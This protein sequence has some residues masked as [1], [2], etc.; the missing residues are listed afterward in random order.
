MAPRPRS[1][2]AK[3]RKRRTQKH[4]SKGLTP[5]QQRFAQ[6]VVSGA[7]SIAEA[8]RRAGYREP[9]VRSGGLYRMFEHDLLPEIIEE[10]TKQGVTLPV[11]ISKHIEQL[12][13][14]RTQ[15]VGEKCSTL[16][17]PDNGVR[18]KALDMLYEILRVKGRAAP[19]DVT[20]VVPVQ[21]VV[22]YPGKPEAKRGRS[23][24]AVE[25]RR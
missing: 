20:P 2:R 23:R 16:E 10:F 3:G 17:V 7:P 21:V 25:V 9:T 18:L 24:V 1:G 8:A 13:A 11:A 4:A 22:Q 15:V 14:K 19:E 5:R 12:N 6:E